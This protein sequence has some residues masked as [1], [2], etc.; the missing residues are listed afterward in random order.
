[1]IKVVTAVVTLFKRYGLIWPEW[2]CKGS[3][4]LRQLIWITWKIFRILINECGQKQP[5][6]DLPFK[7]YMLIIH[8]PALYTNTK[9]YCYNKLKSFD[10]LIG[11]KYTF[12]NNIVMYSGS[13]LEYS[14]TTVW[15]SRHRPITDWWEL[16]MFSRYRDVTKCCEK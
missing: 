9:N 12:P 16:L 14:T 5:Y 10:Q 15:V 3:T 7:I 11:L 8:S 1:M 4:Y 13:P 6:V 2:N